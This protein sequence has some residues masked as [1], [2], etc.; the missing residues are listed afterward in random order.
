[1]RYNIEFDHATVHLHLVS[2]TQ[3]TRADC[4]GKN[5]TVNVKQRHRDHLLLR[6]NGK[7]YDIALSGVDN[8]RSLFVNGKPC[9]LTVLDPRIARLR[10]FSKTASDEQSSEAVKAPMPGL[11]LRILVKEGN[12]VEA[13]DGLVIIEA[14][15][16]ENEIRA[17]SEGIIKKISIKEGQAVDKGALLLR[18]E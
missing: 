10:E 2:G 8:K 9:Q 5:Y 4:D 7:N 12:H 14:M 6:L 15:K 13:N 17:T 18:L 1:M 3:T 16:M 11:V